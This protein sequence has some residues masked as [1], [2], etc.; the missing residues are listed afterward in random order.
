MPF[1]DILSANAD[2]SGHHKDLPNG[3]ARRGLAI[4]TCID[5]RIDPLEAFGLAPGDAKVLRNAGARVTEDVLRSLIIAAHLLGVNRVALIQHTDCGGASAD[6]QKVAGIV[7]SITGNSAEG[8]DFMMIDDQIETL[9]SD[10]QLIRDCPLMPAGT[11]VGE[12]MYDVH[13]GKLSEVS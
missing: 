9:H 2:Y 11:E 4:V 10:S 1:N 12:F 8:M 6:Q 5:S 7:E 13:S 3:R